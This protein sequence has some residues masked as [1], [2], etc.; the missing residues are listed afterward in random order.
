LKA[1]SKVINI[2]ATF[3]DDRT[4]LHHAAERGMTEVATLMI[5]MGADVN[6]ADKYMVSLSVGEH[7]V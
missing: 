4:P 6:A 3:E 5:G 1:D 7:A 2:F